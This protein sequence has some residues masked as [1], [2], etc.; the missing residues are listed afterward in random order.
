M[1]SSQSQLHK[2]DRLVLHISVRKSHS[3][4]HDSEVSLKFTSIEHAKTFGFEHSYELIAYN[5]DPGACSIL[6]HDVMKTLA[7][8]NYTTN[9]PIPHD[10]Y[11]HN[12][13]YFFSAERASSSDMPEP[14]GAKRPCP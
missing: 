13:D 2:N 6:L 12:G 5:R 3:T 8:Y 9:P 14:A 4:R 10:W 1:S 7:R 11:N